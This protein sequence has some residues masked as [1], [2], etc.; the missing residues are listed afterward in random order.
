MT[1]RA[2]KVGEFERRARE[3]RI[4]ERL[5][6]ACWVQAH[7][8]DVLDGAHDKATETKADCAFEFAVN[9]QRTWFAEAERLG[10]RGDERWAQAMARGERP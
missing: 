9:E 4:R 7:A 10:F 6:Q 8:Y 3:R 1:P 5:W 2:R